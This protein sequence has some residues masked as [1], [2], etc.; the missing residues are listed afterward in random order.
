[1]AIIEYNTKA[2][3]NWSSNLDEK[4][5]DY[6]QNISKLY[7]EVE[8][9]IGS[10]FAGYLADEFLKSFEEKKK[11]FMDNADVVSDCA[12]LV[13]NNSYQI[14]S[15]ESDLAGRIKRDNYL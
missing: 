9:F 12:N 13:S 11:F 1:M 2:M 15:S 10:D 6:L 8:S 14:E 4:S 5:S 7:L 3:R